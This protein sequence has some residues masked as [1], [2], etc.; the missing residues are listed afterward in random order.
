MQGSVPVRVSWARLALNALLLCVCAVRPKPDLG[1]GT[2]GS[3]SVVPRSAGK[4]TLVVAHHMDPLTWLE[5][6]M[7]PT[8]PFNEIVVLS[9][10]KKG[11]SNDH[12]HTIQH[13]LSAWRNVSTQVRPVRNRAH[14]AGKYLDFIVDRYNDFPAFATFVHDHGQSWHDPPDKV[15]TLL[16]VDPLRIE[17]GIEF[18]SGYCL[19][20]LPSDIVLWA[21]PQLLGNI[22]PE[23][24]RYA[25]P[26]CAQFTVLRHAVTQRPKGFW[27]RLRSFAYEYNGTNFAGHVEFPEER[28]AD[29]AGFVLEWMWKPIF[30][31][32]PVL[33]S[34]F[35][36][37]PD[38]YHQCIAT[39]L[40][41]PISRVNNLWYRTPGA[42]LPRSSATI[43]T[44]A[45]QGLGRFSDDPRSVFANPDEDSLQKW[46]CGDDIR[47]STL[48]TAIRKLSIY[49]KYVVPPWLQ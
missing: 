37:V 24:F 11:G 47:E 49:V 4:G 45:C 46:G 22:Y 15:A 39:C 2:D 18:L 5:D 35:T 3:T 43:L 31:T 16:S 23:P 33:Q 48:G 27:K 32:L 28:L 44:D 9:S 12:I 17:H 14:E 10:L 1:L 25:Q 20:N 19:E 36:Q 8:G 13:N 41:P 29:G 30:A 26:C 42:C 6:A 40:Q 34:S 38:F 7:V 21:W